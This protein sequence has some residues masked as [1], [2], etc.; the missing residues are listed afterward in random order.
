MPAMFSI[1]DTIF[2]SSLSLSLFSYPVE[3]KTLLQNW[4]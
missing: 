4:R 2:L 3:A 1:L